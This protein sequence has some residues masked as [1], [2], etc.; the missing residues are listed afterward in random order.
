MNTSLRL[1]LQL[2]NRL[3]DGIVC[4]V[5]A[6]RLLPPRHLPLKVCSAAPQPRADAVPGGREDELVE[7][8]LAEVV[9]VLDGGLDRVGV[10]VDLVLQVFEGLLEDYKEDVIAETSGNSSQITLRIVQ[11]LSDQEPLRVGCANEAAADAA[12]G[13]ERSLLHGQVGG[14]R[15]HLS[16]KCRRDIRVRVLAPRCSLERSGKRK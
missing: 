5:G 1:P 11:L 16:R 13:E 7:E 14:G 10:G 9:P 2:L 6:V 12:V 15:G 3:P 4:R 8:G